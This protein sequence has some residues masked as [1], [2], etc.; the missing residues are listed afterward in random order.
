MTDKQIEEFLEKRRLSYLQDFAARGGKVVVCPPSP[1]TKEQRTK[2]RWG[3]N[4]KRQR[5]PSIKT[6][7]K[8][9]QNGL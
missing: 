1:E 3:K 7:M 9:A 2:K 8:E 4:V 5:P 6:L